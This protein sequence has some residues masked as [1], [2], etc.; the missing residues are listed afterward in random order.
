MGANRSPRWRSMEPQVL[1]GCGQRS[2][3]GSLTAG[4]IEPQALDME[5]SSRHRWRKYKSTSWSRLTTERAAKKQPERRPLEA[6]E[7]V[8]TS[9]R[10]QNRPKRSSTQAT[11]ALQGI[12]QRCHKCERTEVCSRCC[13]GTVLSLGRTGAA[14]PA[15]LSTD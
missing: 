13:K 5:I 9:A 15:V 3:T 4:P 10:Y 8:Q 1:G 12:A 14:A 2:L 7:L 11:G 6:S